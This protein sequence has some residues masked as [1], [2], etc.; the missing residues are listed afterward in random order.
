MTKMCTDPITEYNNRNFARGSPTDLF[1]LVSLVNGIRLPRYKQVASVILTE[2]DN[3]KFERG[4][5]TDIFF[6]SFVNENSFPL[7]NLGC[8][9]ML[10]YLIFDFF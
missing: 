1:F 5:P 10:T 3:Q 6:V 7:D 8:G 9:C 4:S 2:D